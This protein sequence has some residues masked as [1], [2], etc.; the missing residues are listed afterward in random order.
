MGR[1]LVSC[2]V[3]KSYVKR[4]SLIRSEVLC[5]EAKSDVQRRRLMRRGK[6]LCEEAMS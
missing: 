4:Q 5:G 2:A 3:A 1:G 6:V